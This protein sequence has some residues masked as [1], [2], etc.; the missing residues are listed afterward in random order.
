MAI[1]L[2]ADEDCPKSRLSAGSPPAFRTAF[3]TPNMKIR[4][5][6]ATLSREA[7]IELAQRIESARLRLAQTVARS[8]AAL[9]AF[10]G[11]LEHAKQGQAEAAQLFLGF[12]EDWNETERAI[13][14]LLATV[15]R[16]QARKEPGSRRKEGRAELVRTLIEARP[17]RQAV[18]WLV[19]AL[20]A[21]LQ[22]QGHGALAKTIATL[23]S[24]RETYEDAKAALVRANMGLVFSMAHKRSEMG[25]ATP[26]LVQEGS[27][28]LMR[29]VDKFDHRRGIKF[30]TYA[31][32]WIRHAI[33]RALSD[34][35]RTIRIP[36]HVLD[37]RYK[38]RRAAQEFSQQTGREPTE[39]E[40]S[41]RTGLSREKVGMLATIPREPKSL[42]APIW[43][44]GEGRLGDQIPDRESSPVDAISAKQAQA[45]LR[46]LLKTLTPREEEVIRLR[47]GIDCPEPLA[48]EE[49][50]QKFA[51][52]R[53]RIRQIEAE[54]LGKLHRRAAN[55]QLDSLLAN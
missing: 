22:T 34:S 42:D 48:L 26:D 44:D 32:W 53:E 5:T 24:C 8:P 27:M 4:E 6:T 2:D 20:G 17:S 11:L 50:G 16:L 37:T 30:G 36:V 14:G 40:L 51:L 9:R 12:G 41:L 28:G 15:Q 55:E 49:V 39:A 23:T 7:E 13:D 54:A 10:R 46:L 43:E 45:R 1:L 21:R 25:L 18:D 19:G 29:A 47:F 3:A 38:V 52:S 33:N 35:A 31:G